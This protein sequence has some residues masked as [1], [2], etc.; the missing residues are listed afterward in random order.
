MYSETSLI[1]N[2]RVH[3]KCS[4]FTGVCF[5]SS[6]ISIIMSEDFRVVQIKHVFHFNSVPYLQDSLY[7]ISYLFAVLEPIIVF[8][9]GYLSYLLADM[10]AFSGIVRCVEREGEGVQGGRREG[11][12]CEGRRGEGRRRGRGRE[13]RKGG[14]GEKTD[15]RGEEKGGE[16]VGGREGGGGGKE[17]DGKGRGREG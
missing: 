13:G 12:G 3:K 8:A 15:W 5:N 16:I 10:F 9:M 6:H 14:G 2:P 1:R 11:G 17:G 4:Y 7:V